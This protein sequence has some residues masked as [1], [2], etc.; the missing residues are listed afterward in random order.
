M[1]VQVPLQLLAAAWIVLPTGTPALQL[2]VA[3]PVRHST[4]CFVS[5]GL[6]KAT[7]PPGVTL[8]SIGDQ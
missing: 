5:E 8:T 4:P 1:N 7:A 3:G 2:G 6:L